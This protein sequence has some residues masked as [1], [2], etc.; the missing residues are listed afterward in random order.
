MMQF[1]LVCMGKSDITVESRFHCFGLGLIPTFAKV[2]PK[3][4]SDDE[5]PHAVPISC[6]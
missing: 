4:K 5:F 3:N 2:N 1:H 6:E